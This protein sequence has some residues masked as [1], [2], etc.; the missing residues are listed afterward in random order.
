MLLCVKGHPDDVTYKTKHVA[1]VHI[2]QQLYKYLELIK[3][4]I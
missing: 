1:Y 4:Q 2:N 3:Q